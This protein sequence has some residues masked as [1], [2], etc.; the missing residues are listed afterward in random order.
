MIFICFQSFLK[1]HVF[2]KNFAVIQEIL[3]NMSKPSAFD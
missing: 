1:K 2:L 3:K